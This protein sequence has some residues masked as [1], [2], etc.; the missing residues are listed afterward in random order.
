[1]YSLLIICNKLPSKYF[2]FINFI[3]FVTPA[4]IREDSVKMM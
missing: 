1:M 4:Y 2:N 3:D